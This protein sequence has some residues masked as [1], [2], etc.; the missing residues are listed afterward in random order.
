MAVSEALTEKQAIYGLMAEFDDPEQLLKAVKR[1]RAEGYRRIEAYTPFPI[2][3][4]VDAL[5]KRDDRVPWIVF[6]SGLAGAC[7]G[8]GLQYYISAVDYPLNVGGRPFH[9]WPAFIPVTF[10]LMVLLAAFGAVL[11]M[12]ILNGLPRP[13][14]PVFNAPRFELVNQ[15]RFFLCIERR[16]PK[17]DPER[18]KQFLQS[19][20]PKTVTEVEP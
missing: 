2:E 14:H 20:D 12:L 15:D 7:A 5:G 4:L 10:E 6:F 13:Y 1:T 9:S 3:G 19:L 8:Y 18:T 11:G 17:F 16:D